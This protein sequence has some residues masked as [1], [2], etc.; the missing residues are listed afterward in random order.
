LFR[1]VT[2]SPAVSS[3]TPTTV[4]KNRKG[5]S[6][7][8]R[9]PRAASLEPGSLEYASDPLINDLRRMRDTVTHCLQLWMKTARLCGDKRA[10]LDEHMCDETVDVTF[11]QMN[12]LV[13]RSASIFQSLGA[14]KGQNVAILGENSARWLMA[15][16]GMQLAGGA[17]AVCGADAPSDE[18]RYI[19]EHSDSA[20]IVVLQGPKLMQKLAK[21][22]GSSSSSLGLFN[23]AHGDVNV[24]K[25]VS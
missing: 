9:I 12:D 10:L 3:T 8:A 23:E 6:N 14:T 2:T 20:G 13:L 17:S 11:A 7:N 21:D 18:L 5:K 1:D 24:G 4:R 22:A 25:R 15:D 19:Y 16:H